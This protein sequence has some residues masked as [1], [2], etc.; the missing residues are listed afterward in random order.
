MPAPESCANCDHVAVYKIDD[1]WASAV[2]YCRSHM[3]H[4]LHERATRGDFDY[5]RPPKSKTKAKTADA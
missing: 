5:P 2:H 4:H 3:P 1:P